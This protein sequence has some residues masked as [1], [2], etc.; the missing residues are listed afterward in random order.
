MPQR[1]LV[2]GG[3]G[4]VGR[5]LVTRLQAEGYEVRI[6]DNLP[7]GVVGKMDRNS[8]ELIKA[9]IRNKDAVASA[10]AGVESVIHLASLTDARKSVIMAEE[11][12]SV[13]VTGTLTLLE[14]C[15]K[16]VSKFIFASSCS[17]YGDARVLP[18]PES[19]PVSPCSPYA[20]TKV[21][22][23]GY[24][25]SYASANGFDSTVFRFFNIYGNGGAGNSYSGVIPEFT[26]RAR[27][28]LAPVI[29][30]DGSQSRDFIF[31]DDV[32]EY[33]TRAVRH[34]KPGTFNIGTGRGVNILALATEILRICH[35]SDL[36]P[37]F[38]PGRLGDPHDSLADMTTASKVFGFSPMTQLETGLRHAIERN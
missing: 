29:Y 5:P 20:A 14:A 34:R 16:S 21:A 35:K 11:Y 1:I 4:F 37:K 38:E 26:R 31:I 36:I 6:L 25:M 10:V 30:G 22:G 28:G 3:C 8:P 7:K 9:D 19:Y 32:V 33:V 15:K 18:T 27:V 12:N 24:A 17:V 2:T 23:E 13:N